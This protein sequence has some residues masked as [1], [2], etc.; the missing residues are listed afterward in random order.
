MSGTH[1]YDSDESEIVALVQELIRRLMQSER[2]GAQGSMPIA[3]GFK[4]SFRPDPDATP[5]VIE[6]V[7]E[8]S[9]IEDKVVV[10][11]ELP[12]IAPENIRMGMTGQTLQVFAEEGGRRY[13]TA[14]P[15]PPCDLTSV[16]T[17]LKHGILEVVLDSI[18]PPEA[19]APG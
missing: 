12:G 10:V 14:A 16:R 7:P 11:T 15:L 3:I 4:V 13:H 8:V 1:A 6:L 18:A 5:D 19:P 9:T 17:R 2:A